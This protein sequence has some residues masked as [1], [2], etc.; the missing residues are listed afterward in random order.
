LGSR[1]AGATR[2]H[3][4]DAGDDQEQD[5][6]VGRPHYLYLRLGLRRPSHSC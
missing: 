6:N 2:E 3:E 1:L 5:G 4:Q